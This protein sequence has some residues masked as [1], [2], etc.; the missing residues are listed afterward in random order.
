M[1]PV[2]TLA[3]DSEADLG[4]TRRDRETVTPTTIPVPIGSRCQEV[5]PLGIKEHRHFSRP[6]W[7]PQGEAQAQRGC[8]GAEP[9]PRTQS[10]EAASRVSPTLPQ[11]G[12]GTGMALWRSKQTLTAMSGVN[13]Q[14]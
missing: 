11:T 13:C 10:G 2:R 6:E 1:S 5:V 4:E 3:F 14:E 9:P 12:D 8:V 7:S